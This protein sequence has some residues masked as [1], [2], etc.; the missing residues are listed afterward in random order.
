MANILYALAGE[1]SGHST[2]S[3]EIIEHLIQ[4]G[5]RVKVVSYDRG[6][7]NLR[8][9]FD[10]TEIAG[11]NFVYKNNEVKQVPTVFQNILRTN[12][13]VASFKKIEKLVQE[14][15]PKII[16]SDFEPISARVAVLKKIPL[17][18]IDNQ[19]FI[20]GTKI[21]YPKKY[22]KDA[23]LTKAVIEQMTPGAKAYLS[24]TFVPEKIIKKN[25]FLFPPILRKEVLK[26]RTS[27]QDYII[28]YL[29]SP[30]SGFIE[31]LKKIR[32][33]FVIYGLNEDRKE[34]N[35]T[36]KKA[37]QEGFLRDLANS[38]GVI[39]NAG[40]SLMSEALYFG[41]P[42]L[43]IPVKGQFEQVINAYYL[44]REGYGKYWDELDREK[45][46]A[47]LFNLNWYRENLEKY[48]REDNSKIFQMVDEIIG[49]YS[50]D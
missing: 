19:H 18:S 45:I 42:Y 27:I 28:I 23:L 25:V 38:E 3:K 41:K 13:L 8:D 46:E 6:Y 26:A 5:H 10:V 4:K 44:E 36:F 43:A 7:K 35:V 49:K 34:G 29:T 31:T 16:I 11:L 17:V 24:I 22:Q 40:F 14:F 21:E 50:G 9:F 2:R 15:Q 39:A 48:P 37:S 30:F 47:F 20:T 1:G 33:K 12:K 32:K